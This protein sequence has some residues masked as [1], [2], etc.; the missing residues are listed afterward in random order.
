MLR[1]SGTGRKK[2]RRAPRR[3][4]HCE[5]EERTANLNLSARSEFTRTTVVRRFFHAYAAEMR[6]ADI[7]EEREDWVYV[8]QV[9]L[10]PENSG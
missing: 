8:G 6:I 1:G 3:E 10:S 4:E 2:T 7:R 5:I 9:T